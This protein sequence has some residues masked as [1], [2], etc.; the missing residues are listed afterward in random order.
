[1]PRIRAVSVDGARNAPRGETAQF[2]GEVTGDVETVGALAPRAR[3]AVYFAPNTPRGF[4]DAVAAAVHDRRQ[5]NT[6]LSISWG[7]AEV[8]WQR[9]TLLA[10][11]RVLL[12]AAVLGITV[13]C[14]SGD[15]GSFAD[16]RDREA[17]VNFPGSSPYVLACGGT[18]LV[19]ARSR[20]RSERVWHNH[21][22]ASG[23]GAGAISAATWQAASAR[24]SAPGRG[25]LT[26]QRT[27][28]MTGSHLGHGQGMSAPTTASLSGNRVR[29]NQHCA[30]IDRR[31]RIVPTFR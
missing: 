27:R 9:S 21:R 8:H 30:A 3:I 22:G 6:V 15:Y 2:D 20:I 28:S 5:R 11:N 18:T 31:R 26:W 23:G 16:A 25:V 19:G 29:I 1:M 10:L 24:G 4:L 13:C 17:H 7:L 12:E 14:S